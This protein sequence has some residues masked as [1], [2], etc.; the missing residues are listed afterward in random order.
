MHAR[1]M[2]DQQEKDRLVI[3]LMYV[4]DAVLTLQRDGASQHAR[5][6]H[7]LDDCN[8]AGDVPRSP[9]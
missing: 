6:P 2:Q 7:L 5:G 9:M 4:G 8:A 3:D 1:E